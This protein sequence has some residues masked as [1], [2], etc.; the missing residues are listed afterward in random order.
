MGLL[1]K[2]IK[3]SLHCKGLGTKLVPPQTGDVPFYRIE[4]GQQISITTI[5]NHRMSI[6]IP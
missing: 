2:V 3:D 1:K 6:T 4:I 5:V